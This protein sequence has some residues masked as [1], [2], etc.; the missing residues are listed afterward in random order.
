MLSL[1]FLFALIS[2]VSAYEVLIGDT[3]LLH[4]CPGC[5]I[6]DR[7]N[8]GTLYQYDSSILTSTIS[9]P[10][11]R[12]LYKPNTTV[13]VVDSVTWGNESVY[14][15]TIYV[16]ARCDVFSIYG[17]N[18][19]IN[20]PPTPIV[21]VSYDRG[22]KFTVQGEYLR[23][24]RYYIGFVPIQSLDG[25]YS[26][27]DNIHE[28]YAPSWGSKSN[29]HISGAL[30]SGC[31][32]SSPEW[33][34]TAPRCN[35]VKYV[36]LFSIDNFNTK[37]ITST[38]MREV[39]V[40]SVAGTSQQK[41]SGTLYIQLLHEY[42]SSYS[43]ISTVTVPF[44]FVYD[45]VITLFNSFNAKKLL[46]VT[47]LGSKYDD[48]GYY[49]IKLRT[50]VGMNK[51]LQVLQQTH[52][53]VLN[54]TSGASHVQEWIYSTSSP[55]Y[56]FDGTYRF[57][58]VL[59][60][61][62]IVVD[63][64]MNIKASKQ[65]SQ[66]REFSLI[67]IIDIYSDGTLTTKYNGPFKKGDTVYIASSMENILSLTTRIQSLWLCY[68]DDP[69][70]YPTY[71]EKLLRYGCREPIDGILPQSNIIP[72]IVNN[73][74]RDGAHIIS[75]NVVSLTIDSSDTRLYYVHAEVAIDPIFTTRSLQSLQH[76]QFSSLNSFSV[77]F[78]YIY[79]ILPVIAAVATLL[80]VITIIVIIL[81][82]RRLRRNRRHKLTNE[83]E[84]MTDLVVYYE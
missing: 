84:N 82:V 69:Y 74:I 70:F 9:D 30:T 81:G 50:E 71:D 2:T 79:V 42:L 31:Y 80:F 51:H 5:R 40:S 38:G 62:N 23:D 16:T 7:P 65:E 49:V 24:T 14:S 45:T 68:S 21:D 56:V 47:V 15:A 28:G 29:A 6:Y 55:N 73:T 46:T 63:M 57:E 25:G 37:C 54:S 33:M 11:G 32:I 76:K 3:L 19:V 52:P 12:F 60:P 13:Q 77:Q 43:V 41:F 61:D 8:N 35:K 48:E 75:D 83:S 72:I 58:W 66:D 22:F 1:L 26:K 39:Q 34:I 27:C 44:S 53:F 36:A 59:H 10:H 18:G 17:D 78:P 20:L 4:G 64:A 67:P